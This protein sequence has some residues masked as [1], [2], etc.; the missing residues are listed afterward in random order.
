MNYI[1]ALATVIS[2]IFAASVFTRYFQRRGTHLLFWAI[3]A[4]IYGLG[5]LAEAALSITYAPI[6]LKLYYLSGAM[7]TAAWLGQGTVFLLV[8]KGRWASISA[9]V[10][11]IVSA[12]GI[13][14]IA[15]A[16]VSPASYDV[17]LPVSA[18]Y[19]AILDRPGYIIALTIILN[20]YGALTLVGGAIYSAYLFW[21]KQILANRMYGNILIAF[22]ALLSAS[23]GTLVL[24]GS[25]DWHSLSLLLGVIFMFAGYLQAVA[26]PGGTPQPG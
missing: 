22:G 5:S 3:G 17:S 12:V 7:L 13:Y 25:I 14:A 21:R 24:F 9:A 15:A 26:S 6:F 1:S 16:G 4:F 8:R 18:Q 20:T 10:L 23:G 2:F 11:I 19:K